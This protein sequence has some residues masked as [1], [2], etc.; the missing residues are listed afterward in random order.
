M[1]EAR[2]PPRP[3]TCS[4]SLVRPGKPPAVVPRTPAAPGRALGN[5]LSGNVAGNGVA[6]AAQAGDLI[7]LLSQASERIDEPKE[8]EIGRHLA[9][10]P[11]FDPYGLVAVLQQL[12]S[13]APQPGKN[14]NGTSRCRRVAIAASVFD[15]RLLALFLHSGQQHD[16]QQ[17]RRYRQQAG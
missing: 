6:N 8:V 1:P 2:M 7:G 11:G 9:A 17:Q 13:V 4:S 15:E 14:A 10:V 5:A 12:R 16:D 3:S